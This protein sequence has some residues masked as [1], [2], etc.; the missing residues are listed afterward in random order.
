LYGRLLTGLKHPNPR[1]VKILLDTGASASIIAYQYVEKLHLKQQQDPLQWKA[2]EGELSTNY[3]VD[4][5][6]SLLELH[7]SIMVQ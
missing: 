5:E 1:T 3:Q 7:E 4:I 6:F 2:A